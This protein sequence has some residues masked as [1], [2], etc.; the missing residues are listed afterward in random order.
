MVAKAGGQAT[1][2]KAAKTEGKRL[3]G[4]IMQDLKERTHPRT[5]M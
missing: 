3:A 1:A 2:G 5:N 4:I